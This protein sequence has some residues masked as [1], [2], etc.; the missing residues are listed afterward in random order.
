[1]LV[2]IGPGPNGTVRVFIY[3][4]SLLPPFQNLK[5][6]YSLMPQ[7]LWFCLDVSAILVVVTIDC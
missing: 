6:R 2:N 3:S 5:K 1:M 7:V 4:F